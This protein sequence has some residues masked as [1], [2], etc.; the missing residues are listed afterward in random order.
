[1]KIIIATPLF[2][3]DIGGAAQYTK[4]LSKHLVEDNEVTVVT[5][6]RIPENVKG[7]NFFCVDKRHPLPVRLFLYTRIVLSAMKSAD[8]VYAQNGPSI[9]LPISI[10]MIL[11]RRPLIV[12]IGDRSGYEHEIHHPIL[13]IIHSFF[14]AH[15][16][17]TLLDIP[18]TRPEILPFESHPTLALANYKN[19]WKKHITTL[20]N[21]FK[22][23]V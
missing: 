3:P 11:R 4:D 21:T 15:A 10:A 16:E 23:Y 18:L 7:V 5:Y 8:I 1:M 13:K 19:S 14:I 9:E 20:N 12:H 22:K 17:K 2:P 6:G